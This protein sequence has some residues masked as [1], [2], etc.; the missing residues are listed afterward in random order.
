MS[1]RSEITVTCPNCGGEHP[2]TV[3]SSIDTKQDPE[4]KKAVRDRSAFLF[5]CPSCGGKSYLDYGLLYHQVEDKIIIRYADSDEQAEEA[6][7]V[8]SLE[9][10]SGMLQDVHKGNYLIRIVRTQ[11]E[12]REKLSIFDEGLDDRIIE[13]FK[14]YV[15]ATFQNEHPGCKSIEMLYVKY[16]GK[17]S[18]QIIA[19]GKTCGTAEIPAKFYTELCVKYS[20]VLED[21]RKDQPYIN[22]KWALDLMGLHP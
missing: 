22:R 13:I 11:N 9:D 15:L 6:S 18:I 10:P 8:L 12:L 7:G 21:M 19:D 3:R 14:I 4:L 1:S 5:T 17:N 16:Q 2:A 20:G